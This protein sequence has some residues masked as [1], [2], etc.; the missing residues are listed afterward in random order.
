MT[1]RRQFLGL[2]AG[3]MLA[4]AVRAVQAKNRLGV[5]AE[6]LAP[7]PDAVGSTLTEVASWVAAR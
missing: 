3:S 4:S 7:G 5:P 6:E 2:I 1:E